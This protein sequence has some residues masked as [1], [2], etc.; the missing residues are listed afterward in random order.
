MRSSR[1]PCRFSDVSVIALLI[2]LSL[3][4]SVSAQIEIPDDA[5]K[6]RSP[7]Q[8]A[9][10]VELPHGFEL[11]LIAA[12][13]LVREPSGVCWDERGRM[14]VCE[15]HGYNLEG[16]FDIEELNKTGKLDRIVRRIEADEVAKAKARVEETGTVKRLIDDDGD[17]K[18]DRVEVWADDLPPC[19]GI[20]PA[21]GGLIVICAPDIVFLADRDGDGRAEVKETLFTG[22]DAGKL[23]RRMNCPQWGVDNWIYVGR[24]TGGRITGPH[25]QGVVDLPRTDFRIKPDGTAIE[26]VTGGTNTFGFAI[27]QVGTRYTVSTGSPAI[28]VAP[29][30]WSELAR[31]RDVSVPGLETGIA[32]YNTTYPISRPHPWRTK[33]DEDPGFSQYYTQHYGRSESAPNGFFTS[34]CSPLIYQDDA[35]PGLRGQLL[36]CEPAQ[37]M[38]H[39]A[40]LKR[41][42]LVPSLH[43][44]ERERDREFL[45]S[46]DTW[47]HPI[48]LTHAPDG[49]IA[50]VDFYREIIEDY[51]AIPR[52]LQQLYQLKH[53]LDYGR[54]WRLTHRDAPRVSSAEMSGMSNQQLAA[55]LASPRFWRRQTARRLLIERR[56]IDSVEVLRRMLGTQSEPTAIL[57]V[58]YTLE[59]LS[60]LKVED[61]YAALRKDAPAVRVHAMRLAER[62]FDDHP[63]LVDEVLQLA[64]DKDPRVLIQLALSLGESNDDRVVPTLA[65]LIREHSDIRW[66]HTAVLSSLSRRNGEMLAELIDEG[67]SSTFLGQLARAIAGG[68]QAD[69]ISRSLVLIKESESR[70]AQVWC[71]QGLKAGFQ[72]PTTIQL[73]NVGFEAL[74]DLT[75]STDSDIRAVARDLVVAM[76]AESPEKRQVRLAGAK[77]ELSDYRLP[78]ERRLAA[79]EEL[80]VED[81]PRITGV[82]LAAFTDA[83]PA[84]RAAILDAVLS[85]RERLPAVVDALEEERLPFA[86]LSALQRARLRQQ[87]DE[88]LRSRVTATF[89]ALA[90]ARAKDLQPYIEALAQARDLSHGEKVFREHCASCHRT[91]GIGYVVG[92]D[93][94]SE[95]RRSEETIVRDIL[96]PNDSITAGFASYLIESSDG[97]SF[98]GLLA[99]ESP[100]S[101]T[102]RQSEGK[103][104][105]V[106]RKDID[107]FNSLSVSLMP[108]GMHEKV[109]PKDVADLLGWLRRQTGRQVLFDEDATFVKQLTDG[110]GSASIARGDR[111]NGHVS[112]RIN[113]PQKFAARIPNWSFRIREHPAQGEYRYLRFAWKSAGARGIMIELANKGRWPAPNDSSFR[114]YSGINSTKWQ[115]VEVDS[116]APTRWELVTRDLWADF[117]DST[118]TGIAPTAMDGP[119]LFD[120]IE[121]LRSNEH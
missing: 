80:S 82:L 100:S 8:S 25:L 107:S 11:K 7:A 81:E 28:F 52:Y 24:G 78:V 87:L 23:E 114:Y 5:P 17:G 98:T 39:R 22:F 57:G 10:V 42:G 60:Q 88:P 41:D 104:T 74:Q 3:G 89:D 97:R 66:M 40:A 34:A 51:S 13:P 46:A 121:L 12:E 79:V 115:A 35:L 61:I 77:R 102:L 37:N 106:L 45:A 21:R 90:K 56:T 33:R 108:E 65:R 29:L 105:I 26:P 99:G 6:P 58:L 119:A 117:G 68:R 20:C 14:F 103:E 91:Q 96:A 109:S 9:S 55:E 111:L 116:K 112:L 59:G 72:Q 1:P 50:I 43:R 110:G 75:K 16:Q 113:P 2:A 27:D 93:L 73:S 83:T 85:K 95:A 64:D 47:F 19:F 32:S 70:P 62:W 53:G 101:V 38:V 118:I 67:S 71:L 76:R 36:A 92:P 49:S 54:V 48:A 4:A 69:A 120:Q 84:V 31:N 44:V 63:K 30:S 18:V 15:L 94:T 86:S